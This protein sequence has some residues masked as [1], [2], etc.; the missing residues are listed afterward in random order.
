MFGGIVPRRFTIP[1]GFMNMSCVNTKTIRKGSD[2][3]RVRRHY[4]KVMVES[5]QQMP[6]CRGNKGTARG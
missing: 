3:V 6:V 4:T 2:V 5:T 1:V